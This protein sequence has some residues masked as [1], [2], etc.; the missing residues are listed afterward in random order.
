MTLKYLLPHLTV[1][2][3]EPFPSFW[4]DEHWF[5][6][7]T[8]GRTEEEEE[9]ETSSD[10]E[11]DLSDSSVEEN[12]EDISEESVGFSS[13]MEEMDRQLGS[14]KIGRSFQKV[15]LLNVISTLQYA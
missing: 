7:I 2:V 4:L 10:E 1:T 9:E 15:K 3:T 5:L 12:G 6:F 13:Y 14:T 8:E 11:D